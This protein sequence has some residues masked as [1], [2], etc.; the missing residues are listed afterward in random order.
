M[1]FDSGHPDTLVNAA[2]HYKNHIK[3]ENATKIS[4]EGHTTLSD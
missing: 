1:R 4:T 2:Q 3:M